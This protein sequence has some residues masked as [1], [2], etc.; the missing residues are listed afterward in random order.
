M[1]GVRKPFLVHF[2]EGIIENTSREK[3]KTISSFL[4]VNFETRFILNSVPNEFIL[5]KISKN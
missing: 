2:V 3:I 5:E 4:V 1:N